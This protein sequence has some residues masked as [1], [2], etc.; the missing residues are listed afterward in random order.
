[1]DSLNSKFLHSLVFSVK[2]LGKRMERDSVVDYNDKI[3]VENKL[4]IRECMIFECRQS[5]SQ[6]IED[7]M[8]SFMAHKL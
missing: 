5:K 8:K 7:L 6:F 1:L 3:V 4:N 2:I